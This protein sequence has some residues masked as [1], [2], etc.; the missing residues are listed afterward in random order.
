MRE[1]AQLEGRPRGGHRDHSSSNPSTTQP[2]APPPTCPGDPSCPPPHDPPSGNPPPQNPTSAAVEGAV[3]SAVDSYNAIVDAYA[4]LIAQDPTLLQ[5]SFEKGPLGQTA[6]ASGFYYYGTR[7]ALGTS[8]VA[9]TS[10]AALGAS[11]VATRVMIHGPHHTFG[12]LGRL[13]HFQLNWWRPG[14]SGSG[15][16]FRVPFPR[17]WWG[18]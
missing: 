14:V 13:P 10:A 11:G 5:Q 18:R 15:G 9:A 3:S 16:A 12:S 2:S 4:G 7:I 1:R 17:G 6:D 8:A